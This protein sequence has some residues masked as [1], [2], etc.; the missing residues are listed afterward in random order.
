MLLAERGTY[1][2]GKIWLCEIVLCNDIAP[3]KVI[4]YEEKK[5]ALLEEIREMEAT[6]DCFVLPTTDGDA[7]ELGIFFIPSGRNSDYWRFAVQKRCFCLYRGLYNRNN[8]LHLPGHQ[9]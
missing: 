4:A 9:F 3:K 7:V 6:P 1:L 2:S 5:Q 8:C